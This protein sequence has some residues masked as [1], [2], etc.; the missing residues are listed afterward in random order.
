MAQSNARKRQ[1]KLE[2]AKKKRAL[3]RKESHR[4][5]EASSPAG[6]LRRAHEAPFGPAWVSE[7]IDSNEDPPSL[8]SALITRRVSGLLLPEVLLVDRTCLGIK[9]AS[10]LAPL[11]ELELAAMVGRMSDQEP[12][13]R[14][15]PLVVQSLAFHALDYARSLGFEP[16]RDFRRALLEPRPDPLLPPTLAL[17]RPYYIPG[18]YDDVARI[19]AQ[20]DRAVGSGNYDFLGSA[21]GVGWTG[22][23]DAL[24]E[25]EDELLEDEDEDEDDARDMG[26]DGAEASEK[27]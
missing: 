7:S 14:C 25:L 11:S 9:D 23:L 17:T 27:S 18:P 5:A 13:Q 24:E 20:L 6:L 2:K 22:A 16:H 26:I 19:V 10:L 1:K 15:E 21:R 4:L 8:I 12:L 3:A